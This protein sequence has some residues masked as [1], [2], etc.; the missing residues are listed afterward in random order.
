MAFI[1]G[2]LA[3]C[4]GFAAGVPIEPSSIYGYQRQPVS[5]GPVVSGTV[6]NI[7]GAA[8][9]PVVTSGWGTLTGFAITDESGNLA[10][11]GTLNQP[12]SADVG[13]MISIPAS[14]IAIDLN[15][16]LPG[17]VVL[18]GFQAA[19]TPGPTGSYLQP[20]T[21]AGGQ[22]TFSTTGNFTQPV[23]DSS[24]TVHGVSG[25]GFLFTAADFSAGTTLLGSGTVAS[26]AYVLPANY[27]EGALHN[28]STTAL[29]VTNFTISTPATGVTIYGGTAFSIDPTHPLALRYLKAGLAWVRA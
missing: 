22:P 24:Y 25:T 18:A 20:P 1:N 2:L 23:Q 13:D 10:Y 28:V 26:G 11:I 15:V 12:I 8:F 7:Y 6:V 17:G 21:V 5:F 4:S 27:G 3:V 16:P 29:T 19:L 14:S 9:G